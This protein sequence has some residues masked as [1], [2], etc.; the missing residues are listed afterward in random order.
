LAREYGVFTI[1]YIH[2]EQTDGQEND[3]VMGNPMNKLIGLALWTWLSN[4]IF[5]GIGQVVSKRFPRENG[6]YFLRIFWKFIRFICRKNKMSGPENDHATR[7]SHW[8]INW[9]SAL[10]II[11]WKKNPQTCTKSNLQKNKT[12]GL[13]RLVRENGAFYTKNKS[14]FQKTTMPEKITWTYWLV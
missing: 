6:G 10:G 13:K 8:H 3:H 9:I 12:N 14:T 1:I 2:K 7:E 11:I 4:R 5:K